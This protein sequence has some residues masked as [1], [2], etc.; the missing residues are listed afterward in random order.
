MHVACALGAA[1]TTTRRN[2][3]VVLLFAR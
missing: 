1:R 2:S 3:G